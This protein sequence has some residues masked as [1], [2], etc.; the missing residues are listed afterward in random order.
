MLLTELEGRKCA[1]C[2][3][4]AFSAL[5]YEFFCAVKGMLNEYSLLIRFCRKF[6]YK[7]TN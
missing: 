3:E 5:L 2:T 1:Y 4:T 6:V 7:Y